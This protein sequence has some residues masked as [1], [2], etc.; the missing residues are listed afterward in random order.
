MNTIE[1][2][3]FI[4][5]PWR[6]ASALAVAAF[7]AA[8]VTAAA[9]TFVVNTV[10]DAP[11]AALNGTCATAAGTCS[12][13]AAMQEAVNLGGGPHTINFSIPAANLVGGVA[14]IVLVNGPL[15][16]LTG[17][18]LDLTINGASQPS[19]L[20]ASVGVATPVGTGPDGIVGTGDEFVLQP[21]PQP[22]VLLVAQQGT[23]GWPSPAVLGIISIKDTQTVTVNG[24]QMTATDGPGATITGLETTGP[25]A[26]DIQAG[27]TTPT[28]G[29]LTVTNSVFGFEGATPSDPG[30]KRR[31]SS[32]SA[33]MDWMDRL[34]GATVNVKNNYMAY[35]NYGGILLAGSD[36][37]KGQDLP[38]VN[39]EENVINYGSFGYEHYANPI[40]IWGGRD[41]SISRN[42]IMHTQ[43]EAA[44]HLQRVLNSRLDDNSIL[45]TQ[46]GDNPSSCGGG[47]VAQNGSGSFIRRNRIE[48]S[49]SSGIALTWYT[50]SSDGYPVSYRLSQNAIARSGAFAGCVPASSQFYD[51]GTL[52]ID[53]HGGQNSF[54]PDLV[55]GNTG[56]LTTQYGNQGMNY[57]I[58]TSAIYNDSVGTLTAKGYV[59][60]ASGQALFGG[61]RV[62]FFVAADDGNNNG[63]VVAGDGLNVPHGEGYGFVGAC[64]AAADGTFNCVLAVPASL[65]AAV[66]AGKLT[67]T[68]TLCSGGCVSADTPGITSE[69]GA[70]LL[71]AVLAGTPESAVVVA[72]VGDSTALPNV[73]SNDT[74]NGQPATAANSTIAV[75]G[76]WPAGI[77]LDP[78]TGTVAVAPSVPAG[79]YAVTYRLCDLVTPQP[80]CVD[81]VDTIVVSPS[82]AT[83]PVLATDDSATAVPNSV[84]LA[85]IRGND[86]VAGALATAANSTLS[87]V[88]TWPAGFSLDPT[89]G[90]VSVGA[91]VTP[92]V[93][94][95]TYQ[96][97][98]KKAPPQCTQAQVTI[99]VLKALPG[100]VAV[101]TLSE[102]TMLLLSVL[103][104]ALGVA[105][106]RRR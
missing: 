80:N 82:A 102:W 1:L 68:A 42:L 5:R 96:L 72:G 30:R 75:V 13:R 21:V 99:T 28:I 84:A 40:Q 49:G 93:Y 48:D 46:P 66:A 87:T 8:P 51:P 94:T 57:P 43:H 77:V 24:I 67:S 27:S 55:T 78:S 36:G 69:F 3:N 9:T 41:S 79:S 11:D 91:A 52:G 45:D 59:G 2:I 97:C 60:S 4:R 92:G 38:V 34:N 6:L 76:A 26:F 17:S 70:S 83:A 39:I 71:I 23:A 63:P 100:T 14:R 7:M 18:T 85:D 44:V 58:L 22:K 74:I 47:I 29:T 10:S 25:L 104:L 81:V 16:L 32:F 33:V 106:M 53:L 56:T 89:T 101:P 95:M 90:A 88:G 50:V 105:G 19:T 35:L 54:A 12:L 64:D 15:P 62:E 61:S 20:S 103:M 37:D 98:D 65:K 73:R 31:M 86:T